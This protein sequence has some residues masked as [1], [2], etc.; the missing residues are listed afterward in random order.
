MTFADGST[1]AYSYA[2]DGTKLRTVHNI[3]GATTQ[4]DYCG[5]VIYENDAAKLWQT[6]AGYISMNDRK[7]QYSKK[8]LG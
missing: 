7:Y 6:E 8:R 5:S 1:I 3:N 2:A 4:K